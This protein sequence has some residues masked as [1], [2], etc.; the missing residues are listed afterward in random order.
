MR[1]VRRE[2]EAEYERRQRR[3]YESDMRAQ[4]PGHLR[5]AMQTIR[6][7]LQSTRGREA[8]T[9]QLNS[10]ASRLLSIPYELVSLEAPSTQERHG[11][12]IAHAPPQNPTASSGYIGEEFSSTQL[13]G[14]NTVPFSIAQNLAQSFPLQDPGEISCP[15]LNDARSCEE[16]DPKELEHIFEQFLECYPHDFPE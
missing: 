10:T 14:V 2:F 4:L 3:E 13:E 15:R 5:S 9:D 12:T 1:L 8:S 11:Q 6:G 7:Q 16:M